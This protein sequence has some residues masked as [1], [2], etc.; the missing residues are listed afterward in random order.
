VPPPLCVRPC[1]PAIWPDYFC[2]KHRSQAETLGGGGRKRRLPREEEKRP[3]FRFTRYP[4]GRR[5]GRGKTGARKRPNFLC[6][7]PGEED[8]GRCGLRPT[9]GGGEAGRLIWG[10]HADQH[11]KLCAATPGRRIGAAAYPARPK[12]GGVG[13]SVTI[14]TSHAA[15]RSLCKIRRH[16]GGGN[17]SPLS[18]E[19]R[20]GGSDPCNLNV[21]CRTPLQGRCA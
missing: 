20:G 11:P 15:I 4:R 21:T 12:G 9:S 6:S 19:V 3:P 7:D 10:D 17:V 13:R 5:G 16:E 8:R 1:A 14:E 18:H 2:A